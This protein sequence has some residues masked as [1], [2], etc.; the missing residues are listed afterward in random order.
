MTPIFQ[1]VTAAPEPAEASHRLLLPMLTRLAGA[2]HGVATRALLA[3]L[4]SVMVRHFA[5][6]E[7]AGGLF[8][9]VLERAP[10][11][12]MQ[13]AELGAEHGT[14]LRATA[15]LEACVPTTVAPLE[16]EVSS[17]IMVVVVRMRSHESTEETMLQRALLRDLS[18]AD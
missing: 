6:E 18:A 2:P 3:E 8:E 17:A 4:G 11:Y 7:G 10:H 1:E 12:Q 13:I 5:A 16:P 15:E 14:I 9:F